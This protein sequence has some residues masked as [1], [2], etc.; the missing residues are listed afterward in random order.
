MNLPLFREVDFPCTRSNAHKILKQ[1]RKFE[2][3]AGRAKIDIRSPQITDMP[4]SQSY[5]NKTEDAI[6]QFV[7]AEDERD[8]ILKAITSLDL[9]KRQ[10]LYY[11]YCEPESYSNAFIADKIGYSERQI[12]RLKKEA[13]IYF[14]EAYRH[15]KLIQYY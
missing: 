1:Y 9:V 4:K 14:A 2:R 7:Y 5:G 6:I 11:C 3:I 13:L 10:I 12:N 8:E 15:G